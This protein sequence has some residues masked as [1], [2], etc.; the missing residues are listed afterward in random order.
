MSTAT[1][2]SP[3]FLLGIS[4]VSD[5][6]WKE[7]H[8]LV[9]MGILQILTFGLDNLI[10]WINYVTTNLLGLVPMEKEVSWIEF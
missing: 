6:L 4:A 3:T 5:F 7:G 9:G 2:V 10:C 1:N 8:A